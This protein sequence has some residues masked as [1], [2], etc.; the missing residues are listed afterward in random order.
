MANM[1]KSDYIILSAMEYSFKND[2]EEHFNKGIS[3]HCIPQD[4]LE[5]FEDI[6]RGRNGMLARGYNPMKISIPLE[7]KS[8][9]DAVPGIYEVSYILSYVGGNVKQRIYGLNFLRKPELS[10]MP[11]A[12]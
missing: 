9:I 11:N 6:Y 2:G 8:Q 7:L 5:P 3:I 1:E 10:Q 4:N 12:G